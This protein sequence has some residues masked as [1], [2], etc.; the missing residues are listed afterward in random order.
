MF[1]GSYSS[2]NI[3][4][5]MSLKQCSVAFDSSVSLTVLGQDCSNEQFEVVMSRLSSFISWCSSATSANDSLSKLWVVKL[6]YKE[7]MFLDI[8]ALKGLR[9]SILSLLGRVRIIC[10]NAWSS[11]HNWTS[12]NP[13][14]SSFRPS[15]SNSLILY[16]SLSPFGGFN[17]VVLYLRVRAFNSS[18]KSSIVLCQ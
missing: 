15:T 13:Y 12:S 10:F 8:G 4:F 1:A 6:G 17:L 14:F 3:M 2:S 7:S 5:R 18:L 16:S 9:F 11:S